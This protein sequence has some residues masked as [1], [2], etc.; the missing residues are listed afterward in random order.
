MDD[1]HCLVD[2][3]GG[4]LHQLLRSGKSYVTL[5]HVF[6]THVHT[7]HIGDLMPLLHALKFPGLT[8]TAP[9]TLHGPPGFQAF[10]DQIIVPTVGLPTTFPVR[11]REVEAVQKIT[12]ALTVRTAPTVHSDKMHSVA[13]R[14]ES[15]GR[16]LVL[17]GDADYDA[18][19]VK[20][21]VGADCLVADCSSLDSGKLPGHMS[22]GLC[23]QLA[24][25]AGVGHL[26]LSHLYPILG[27]TLG[28]A[29][30]GEARRHY[31]G[32][33]ALAKDSMTLMV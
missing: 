5:D 21:A 2:C 9:L 19:L 25:E 24:R 22:A 27:P 23:G 15:Q 12:P 10:V 30:I 14:F 3:G 28:T 26:V 4:T 32:P 29:R 31:G 17:T 8:R 18:A 33:I 11:V 16:V 20:L 7:D 6:I 13:Y 1:L